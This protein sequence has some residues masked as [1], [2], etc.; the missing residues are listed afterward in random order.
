MCIFIPPVD[1]PFFLVDPCP[2]SL[3]FEP[4]VEV[5][6]EVVDVEEVPG[7]ETVST[8]EL[9]LPCWMVNPGMALAL[10]AKT[11]INVWVSSSDD[12]TIAES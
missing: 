3:R 11:F 10:L 4:D 8:R 1:S 5:D 9:T 7:P 12:G 2:L 6:V